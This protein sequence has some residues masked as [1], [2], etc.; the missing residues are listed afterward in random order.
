MTKILDLYPADQI[1]EHLVPV[2][3][4]LAEDGV[5]AVRKEGFRV[6]SLII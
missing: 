4:D 3:L 6:A 5:S 2:A 1:S